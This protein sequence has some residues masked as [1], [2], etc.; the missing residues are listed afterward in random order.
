M[1]YPVTVTRSTFI[2]TVQHLMQRIGHGTAI[3][4]KALMEAS[5]GNRRLMQ[6]QALQAKSDAELAALNIKRDEIV[7]RV[8]GLAL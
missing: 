8:F 3:F 4:G 5:E 1:S 7:Q 6:V 2:E